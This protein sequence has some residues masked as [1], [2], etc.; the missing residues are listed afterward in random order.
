MF[1]YPFKENTTILENKYEMKKKTAW[2]LCKW[3]KVFTSVVEWSI[4]MNSNITL[5]PLHWSSTAACAFSLPVD[6]HIQQ[7]YSEHFSW[8]L[9]MGISRTFQL[10]HMLIQREAGKQLCFPAFLFLTDRDVLGRMELWT[11]QTHLRANCKQY[12]IQKKITVVLRDVK[13]ATSS[14]LMV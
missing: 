2:K 9:A 6:L 11:R 5:L 13:R 10:I 1:V 7:T 3:T 4:W 8:E 12:I 14:L